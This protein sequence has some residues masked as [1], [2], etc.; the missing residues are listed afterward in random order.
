[1]VNVEYALM[2]D[3]IKISVSGHAGYAEKG[4][5]IV[6]AGVSALTRALQEYIEKTVELW[7]AQFISK[8]IRD[9]FMSFSIEGIKDDS[10]YSNV[11]NTVFMCILG[12]EAIEEQYPDYIKIADISFL[13]EDS[14]ID[15]PEQTES[16]KEKEEQ[17]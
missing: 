5:D 8:S 17:A 13:Y 9:G 10:L 15:T 2:E 14:D 6:C 7:D 3:F 11:L 1:M 4:K 16:N 12:L